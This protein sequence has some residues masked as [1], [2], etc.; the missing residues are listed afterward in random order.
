MKNSVAKLLINFFWLALAA[1]LPSCVLGQSPVQQ[2][3]QA[4]AE[5][6]A[7]LQSKLPE[8]RSPGLW[9]AV[10]REGQVTRLAAVGVRK[11]GDATPATVQDQLHIGSCTKAMTATLAAKLVEVGDLK[12]NSTIEEVLPRLSRK[13]HESYRGVNLQ[14]LL[15]HRAGVAANAKNWWLFHGKPVVGVRRKIAED[16]L[17]EPASKL[18]A[19]LYSNL[20]YMLAGMMIEKVKRK[21][22]EKCIVDELFEPLEMDSAGFG[23]PGTKS[24]V[25]Q[26]WGHQLKSRMTSNQ[27][28]NAPALGPAGTVHLSLQDW[29]KFARLHLESKDSFL[30]E[31]SFRKLH[32]PYVN[33]GQRYAMGWL[34]S[35]DQQIMT[36][37][38]SNT[39]WYAT[40]RIDKTTR[41][42]Y[43]VA[44][45][46]ADPVT[47]KKVPELVLE[48]ARNQK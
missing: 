27:R 34:V 32:E 9:A 48:L 11:F 31:S 38:G 6:Q 37:S 21:P 14:Q 43:I 36:H 28:D 25:R 17:S 29:L 42:V 35:A 10:Y 24:K 7:W 41:S 15:C 12:W 3:P 4:D 46:I 22:W 39:F 16:S 1:F 18:D 33:R 5:L 8:T 47:S 13:I 23:P 20:G 26:P 2:G 45:N 19:Y 40:I 44:A 30:K